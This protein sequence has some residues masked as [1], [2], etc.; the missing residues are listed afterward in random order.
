M[1]SVGRHENISLLSYSEVE[2]V[3]GYV[4]N[5]KVRVHRKARYVDETKCTGC[6]K[7]AEACPVE[8][9]NPFDM[10]L[11]TRKATYRFSAQSVPGAY[12][13]QKKGIA[14]CR[15]A[16]PTDQRAQGYIALIKQK[17]YADAYWAIRR[18]HP[19][20]SVCGRVCNHRCEDAC[21]RGQYDEPV[22]IMGLKRFVADWAFAHRD[23]LP[24]MR[25]KSLVGTPFSHTP[26]PTGKKIAIIGAGPAGMTA[27]LDL[28][29]IGHQATVFDSLPVAGGMMR[30]G[31][32]P[33][34]L[35][36]D[37][38]DWEVKQILDEGVKLQLNTWVDDIPALLDNG[39]HAV[40]IATGAH[41]TKKLP[42]RNSNH[43]DNWMSLD[44]LRRACIGDK[45]E[46]AGKTVAVL[47]GGNV[48][49]D[50]AR[51]LLRLGAD[52]VHMVCLEP[53]GE[54][55]GFKWEVCVAE[56]EGIII[57]SGRTFKEIVV[58]D[59]VI[60]GVRC[61]E[62]EF[63]GFKHGRPDFNEIPGTEH[64]I[65]A[66]LIVWAIGQAPNFSF[67]PQDGSINTRYPVG[68]QS[69]NEMMTTMKGVF[70]AGDVHRGVTFFVVDAI[71][72]GHHA[73]RSID[74]FL[75]GA[76]GVQEPQK[77]P[78][79]ELKKDDIEAKFS[80]GES[81][82]QTRIPISSI[83][84]DERTHNFK[85]V[86]LTLTEQQALSEAE[87]CLRCGICSECLECLSACERGAINHDM[88]DS[89]LDLTVGTIVLATGFKDFDPSRI[90]ELGYGNL[91][92]VLSSM[93]FERL[94][95]A[96]GPTSGKVTLKNGQPPKSVA[97]VHCV[98]SR[99]D[100]YN[101]YCSRACCMY[102]LKLA[103]LVHD[104]V[105]AEV[106]EIYR[107]MRT[108]GK[109]YEEFYNRTRTKGIHFYH[110]RVKNITQQDGKLSVKWDEAFHNQPDHV[111][112]DM[113]ILSTGFEAQADAAKVASLFGISRSPDGFF[114]EK[115]PK[116]APVETSTEGIYLAG[117]CQSP[118]DIPDSVAQAGGAAAAALS[119]L[120]QGTIA[121]DPSIA[122]VNLLRC[123]GC[124]QCV[125]A[126]PY[127]AI[128]LK[129]SVASVNSYLCKGCGTCAATC[130]DKAITLIHFDDQQIVN[131]MIGALAANL[132]VPGILNL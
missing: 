74:R 23:E 99:D 90:P 100:K 11:S 123:A 79:V 39:Y 80:H 130:R 43:P 69:D 29:R 124:G 40:L 20:P 116:L 121:L 88:K 127:S 26:M 2:N 34:R 110:G 60:K 38:L 115:H 120:D 104:Y 98:G 22:N 9:S 91:D 25:D 33:H 50:S 82:R 75:R 7:C 61:V 86:D 128:E 3:S 112:V 114:L 4:G 17:R 48:A 54:M 16:C 64:I 95:N 28:V 30:V 122:T 49:L 117:A 101:E 31:I 84:V 107:D 47:G 66:D 15:A 42:I 109:D 132:L 12:T 77:L 93:E 63:R 45:I 14:P 72:E 32:P 67:L 44:V 129:E 89:I 18:E 51:T 21:S 85:E 83:A 6:G 131:E 108:F 56:E 102:S 106:H 111:E 71:N 13:I 24:N 27:A 118:K 46:L 53:R 97:I 41:Q 70:V 96:S 125:E 73:A 59:D 36:T 52:K 57:N 105:H 62:I 58:K 65:P 92:N 19:F 87:R 94:I 81:S 119:L 37:Y 126:C 103:Q 68:V 1:V 78:T 55:P 5:Y 10:D 35:P 76:D 113:V 8:V